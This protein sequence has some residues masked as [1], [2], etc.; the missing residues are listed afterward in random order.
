MDKVDENIEYTCW[1]CSNRCGEECGIDGHE[2][3]PDSEACDDY[4]DCQS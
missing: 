4:S 2:V 1:D 3:Y